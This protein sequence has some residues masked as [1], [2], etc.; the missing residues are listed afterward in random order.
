[1][2]S[3]FPG[4]GFKGEKTSTSFAWLF[5]PNLIFPGVKTSMGGRAEPSFYG[6]LQMAEHS[7]APAV[8][9]KCI[10]TL[11]Q[12]C[13]INPKNHVC[14]GGTSS[15]WPFSPKYP[16][17]LRTLRSKSICR[18]APTLHYG[19]VMGCAFSGLKGL[20]VCFA[21]TTCTVAG[22]TLQVCISRGV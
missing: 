15:Y 6:C 20:S 16:G 14:S 18:P 11:T 12:Q 8:S 5:L 13:I 1:M 21:F 9:C 17:H 22:R 7:A 3:A 10:L 19:S 4:E 2:P